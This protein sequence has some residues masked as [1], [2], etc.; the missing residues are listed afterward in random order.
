M[1]STAITR[2]S[3]I[4]TPT[5]TPIPTLAA[6][7]SVFDEFPPAGAVVGTVP[8]VVAEN[9][10]VVAAARVPLELWS[11]T[12]VPLGEVADPV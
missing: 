7:D 11:D 9:V 5:P 12:V 8:C 1:A 3:R 4:P 2:M 10:G 6:V